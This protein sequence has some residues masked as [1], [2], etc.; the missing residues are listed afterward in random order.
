MNRKIFESETHHKQRNK[1][2]YVIRN[3]GTGAYLCDMKLNR[4]VFP[5]YRAAERELKRLRLSHY[6]YETEVLVRS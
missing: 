3:T 4:R 1:F 2:I 6:S 5:S